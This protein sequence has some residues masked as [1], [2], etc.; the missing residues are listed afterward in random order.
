L[1][2]KALRD[3]DAGL[4]KAGGRVYFLFF[5]FLFF[6]LFYLQLLAE[7]PE[8]PHAFSLKAL[9][10]ADAGLNGRGAY[11]THPEML[12]QVGALRGAARER[13]LAIYLHGTPRQWLDRRR[14]W[15]ADEKNRMVALAREAGLQVVN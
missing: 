6:Y 5:Y 3:A 9:H 4:N 11:L 10:Y 2:L 8:Q 7:L 13:P 15:I 1:S 14:S 12:H